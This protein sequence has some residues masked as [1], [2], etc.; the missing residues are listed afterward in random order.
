V[1]TL[2]DDVLTSGGSDW[3]D[4]HVFQPRWYDTTE[5]D[6]FRPRA[7][8]VLGEEFG[9]ARMIVFKDP[10]VC[11]IFPFWRSVF[12]KAGLEAKV[13]LAIRHPVEVAASLNKRNNLS[14][15]HGLLLWL[16]HVLEAEYAS[17][18]MTRAAVSFEGF[19][20]DPVG[21]AAA[22]QD[23]LGI[24]WP[25]L[26]EKISEQIVGSLKP[27]LRHHRAPEQR[28]VGEVPALHDWLAEVY[29]ILLRWSESGEDA[30]D[31]IA[32]DH[33]RQSMNQLAT[34][35]REVIANL[36]EV[37]GEKQGLREAIR[38]QDAKRIELKASLDTATYK[39]ADL[40]K[41]LKAHNVERE[42]AEQAAKAAQTELARENEALK[43]KLKAH[44][45]ALRQAE[46]KLLQMNSVLRQRAHEAKQT[47]ADLSAANATHE[48]QQALLRTE[49][50]E[51]QAQLLR[52][53]AD[54]SKAQKWL[55]EREAEL[56]RVREDSERNLTN[57]FEE[58]AALTRQLVNHEAELD[59]KREHAQLAQDL[60]A[61]RVR[62]ISNTIRAII[63]GDVL[64][65]KLVQSFANRRKARLLRALGLFDADWYVRF[66][67]DLR[68]ADVDPT[69]HFVRYG[70][71]E[72]RAASPEMLNLQRGRAGNE[73]TQ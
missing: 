40:E 28:Q 69:I 21:V 46:S 61:R 42:V 29:E 59:A 37:N 25:R 38:K 68:E 66:Y 41:Q 30:A 10:R 60:A 15:L 26:S 65:Y 8:Q 34:P 70:Y 7:L 49:L 27:E 6:A 67:D 33:V 50:S 3:Q 31:Y 2:N 51:T 16:R 64:G 73:P 52:D 32:L 57:R 44:Q 14:D 24:L 13:I 48:R 20:A 36:N 18:G 43:E 12:A 53:Q 35:M 5:P 39:I 17:R 11:R 9:D 54:L 4:W 63:E 22:L 23:Q 71:A 72:G 58:I 45:A 1:R 55:F 47:A 56:S 19:M 62:R